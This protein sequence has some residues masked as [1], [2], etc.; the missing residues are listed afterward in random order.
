MGETIMKEDY[1]KQNRKEQKNNGHRKKNT[2]KVKKEIAERVEFDEM[3]Q[4][5]WFPID[6]YCD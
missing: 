4:I 6:P 5:E 2:Q 3:N 1:N